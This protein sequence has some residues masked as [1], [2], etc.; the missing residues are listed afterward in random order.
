MPRQVLLIVMLIAISFGGMR[1][2]P[3]DDYVNAPDSHFSYELIKTYT[4]T[5]YKLYILN[6]T[7]QKWLDE[8]IVKNPIWWHYLCITIPDKLTRLDAGLLL[9]DGGSN[10][11]G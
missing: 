9:I 6:M 3:L 2:T 1:S 11:D 7:S 10:G 5:G 8:T 4:M